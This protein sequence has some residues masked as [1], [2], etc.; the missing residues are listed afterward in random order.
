[1]RKVLVFQHVAHRI[2]GTLN[3]TIKE[4][5]LRMRYVNFERNPDE[6]PSIEKY[7][8][9]IVLGGHMGV[10]EADKYTHIKVEMKLI[11][12]ALKKDIPILGISLGAQLLV[13]VLGSEVRKSPEKEIGWY[14][15]E[16]KDSALKDPLFSHFKKSEKI[17]QL[18]GDTF[19][20]PHC[21]Q[22]LA[23][24][25]LCPAQAFRY[26]DKVYGM[27]FHLEVDKP[28]IHR[29]LDNPINQKEINESHGKFSID[30]IRNETDEH[31][32]HSMNLSRETF[33]KFLGLFAWER[34]VLL[35]SHHEKLPVR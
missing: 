14:D 33:K 1:M 29:W 18:H 34:P 35:G 10:Y 19:D 3:P 32:Q 26:G 12:E 22:H 7:N 2:L 15:I 11:E 31:I 9:L 24:S 8:G 5:G 17:F 4:H 23:S 16:L 6:S 27:Q 20:V 13:H 25:S 28:M 30:R 21:A